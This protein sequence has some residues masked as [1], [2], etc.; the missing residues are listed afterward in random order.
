MPPKCKI[1]IDIAADSDDAG[2]DAVSSK[3]SKPHMESVGPPSGLEPQISESITI[4]KEGTKIFE[5]LLKEHEKRD[6]GIHALDMIAADDF[7]GAGISEIL[8]NI[9][10]ART[11][12]S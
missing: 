5:K 11:L 3:K 9:V 12:L 4:S 1:V 7:D 10:C 2:S 8:V 6:P